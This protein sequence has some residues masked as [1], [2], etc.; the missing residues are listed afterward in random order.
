MALGAAVLLGGYVPA[1]HA[2]AADVTS[3]SVVG[4]IV[5]NPDGSRTVTIAGRWAWP[6]HQSD[7]NI[8][9]FGVG[10]A[11]DWHDPAAPGHFLATLD[12]VQIHVGTPTDNL[13]HYSA[14]APFCGTY[15]PVAGHNS[16]PIEPI[17]HTY[18][19]G[20]G[21]ITVC[22]VT[23]DIHGDSTEGDPEGIKDG[24][25]VAGG[26]NHNKDNSVESNRQTPAG[27]VC[28]EVT[29][30]NMTTGITTSLTGGG[31]TGAAIDVPVGTAVTDQAT[32]VDATA[33]AG[34]TVTYTVYSD[35]SC[36]PARS[37]MTCPIRA[38]MTRRC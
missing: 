8:D 32:L 31:R 9:R 38:V 13:V 22:V 7:C 36:S 6:T 19:A 30:P 34:G 33:D 4:G 25:L 18:P 5:V 11:V 3:T 12:G 28:A 27:N 24:D 37:P 26:P 23:Y 35:D 14:D 10:W 20:S 17:S 2:D 1:V 29:F 21:P 16:G 15:D